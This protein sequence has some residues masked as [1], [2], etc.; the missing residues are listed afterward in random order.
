MQLTEVFSANFGIEALKKILKYLS[1]DTNSR[2]LFRLDNREKVL[3][4][5]IDQ[6]AELYNQYPDLYDLINKAYKHNIRLGDEKSLDILSSFFNKT[7]TSLRI[8]KDFWQ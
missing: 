8:F 2:V 7:E 6:S 5:I 1:D 4:S 3:K